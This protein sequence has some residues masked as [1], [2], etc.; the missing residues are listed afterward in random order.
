M[1]IQVNLAQI[2]C[3]KKRIIFFVAYGRCPEWVGT[4]GWHIITILVLFSSIY[5][6]IAEYDFFYKCLI[7]NYY[8]LDIL[9][10]CNWVLFAESVNFN[11]TCHYFDYVHC[12]SIHSYAVKLNITKY[13]YRIAEVNELKFFSLKM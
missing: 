4:N 9:L 2:G 1:F 12:R 11:N 10:L 5:S 13:T 8:V 7:L 6:I 3:W